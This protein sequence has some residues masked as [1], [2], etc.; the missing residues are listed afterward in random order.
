[1]KGVE[2]ESDFVLYD[3][4]GAVVLKGVV[5]QVDAHIDTHNLQSGLYVLNINGA[6]FRVI[7]D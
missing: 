4:L 3:A 2:S 5:S 1:V 6:V 7:K